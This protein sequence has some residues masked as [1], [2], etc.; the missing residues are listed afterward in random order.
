MSVNE[1]PTDRWEP[2]LRAVA[3]ALPYP[4]T[5]DIAAAVRRRLG[6]A[7]ARPF[8]AR[9]PRLA[10]AVAVVV[11]VAAALLAAPEVR[12]GLVEFL[13]VGAVRIFLGA[14]TPTVA[15]GE[16]E[17][18]VTATPAAG[19][20]PIVTAT[21][22]LIGAL[23]DLGGETTLEGARAR[24]GFPIP[25]PTHPDGLGP[26]DRVFLQDFGGPMV[27]LV[28]L[29]PKLPERVQFSLLLLTCEVCATK[30]EPTIIQNTT[31]NG[32]PAL[33]TEGPHL[34]QLRNGSME[35]RQLVEGHV[36]IWTDGPITYRLETD[37]TMEEAVRI[38]ESL[39]P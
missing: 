11:L 5:P 18:I 14:P 6:A 36:L 34:L 16:S 31:V 27:V 33:W 9:R 30:S 12:A 7:S 38:A 24:F 2:R 13:R 15:P 3:S 21:P 32:E 37:A 10:W 35:V 26:P 4:P 22:S 29:N 19:A 23:V 25:L 39:K 17:V 8:A 28:W 20:L 1:Q